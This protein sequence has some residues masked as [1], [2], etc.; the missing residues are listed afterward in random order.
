M[1]VAK[2][3]QSIQYPKGTTKS[4]SGKKT[5]FNIA[6]DSCIDAANAIVAAVHK[7]KKTMSEIVDDAYNSISIDK[8]KK[9]H[10]AGTP[11]KVKDKIKM[12]A[13]KLSG[14]GARGHEELAEKNKKLKN[15]GGEYKVVDAPA[16]E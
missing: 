7:G 5:L 9:I 14:N 2:E 15:V 1:P 6:S 16:K 13:G 8:H 3:L 10:K 12:I 11:E 4:S